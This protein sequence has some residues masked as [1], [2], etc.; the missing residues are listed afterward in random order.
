MNM[1]SVLMV[2]DEQEVIEVIMRKL[3]WEELGFRVCGSASNGAEA[4]EMAEELQPDVV[5][6]DIKMPYMDGLELS[7]HLKSLF[8]DIRIII[9]SGFDEFE[10]AKE[11]IR[12]EAEEYLLKPI[13]SGEVRRV[14]EK[15][16]KRLDEDRDRRS[17]VE[18]L[19][20]YYQNSLPLLRENFFMSLM[21]GHISEEKLKDSLEDYSLKLEGPVYVVSIVHVSASE[22]PEGLNPRLMHFSVRELAQDYFEDR[23]RSYVFSYRGNILVLSQLS[24]QD[25]ISAYTDDCDRFCRLARRSCKALTTVGISRTT[26]QIREISSVYDGAREA[27]SYRVIYGTGKAI[28]IQEIAPESD[29]SETQFEEILQGVFKQIRMGNE[30]LLKEQIGRLSAWIGR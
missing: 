8:P 6:T 23:W 30:D 20:E 5:M 17:S 12:L 9:F 4:L 18:R 3:N 26:T 24:S 28:N 7:W 2:D 14:F 1:Y 22:I 21:E 13:D 27:V 15:V 16:H 29:T 19:E 11:A 25:E 10:Y